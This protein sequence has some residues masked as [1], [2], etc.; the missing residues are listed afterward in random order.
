MQQLFSISIVREQHTE[1]NIPVA[2]AS[3]SQAATVEEAAALFFLG[4]GEEA[5]RARREK[6]RIELENCILKSAGK[7]KDCWSGNKFERCKYRQ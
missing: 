7:K 4:I 3:E 6:A 5:T 2:A 1:Q